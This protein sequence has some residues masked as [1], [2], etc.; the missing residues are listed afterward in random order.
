HIRNIEGPEDSREYLKGF[1]DRLEDDLTEILMTQSFQDLTGQIIKKVIELIED[2]E[3]ELVNLVATFGVKIEE[4]K[5]V[6]VCE[7]E[8]VSQSDVDDLLK[9]L[10][11]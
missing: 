3:K 6:K 11:F 4:G 1:K 5:I 10:G 9:D 8:K 2:V 7:T